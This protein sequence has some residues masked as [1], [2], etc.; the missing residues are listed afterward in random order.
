MRTRV[1]GFV[2]PMA[3]RT[4]AVAA[5]VTL[6]APQSIPNN[7]LTAV[8]F[9]TQVFSYG[10]MH[11]TV[12]NNSRLTVPISGIYHVGGSVYFGQ[13]TGGTRILYI[14]K[15]GVI[16][17][18]ADFTVPNVTYSSFYGIST[19]LD[20]DAGDYFEFFVYQDSGAAL[21]VSNIYGGTI[22]WAM[23]VT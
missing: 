19:L 18:R 17:Q 7:T 9:G 14:Y 10:G 15:N 21:N 8:S 16:V 3:Q 12:T 23:L 5:K 13:G 1:P 2:S 11:N 6:S 4:P 20:A 22:F